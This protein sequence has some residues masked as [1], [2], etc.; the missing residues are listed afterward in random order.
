[1][2]ATKQDL[3]IWFGQGTRKG[4]THMI[5]VQDRFDHGNYP[6]YVMPGED[7]NEREKEL[8]FRDLAGI[9]EIYDLTGDMAEQMSVRRVFRRDMAN[10][11]G[12][13][14]PVDV[15]VKSGAGAP[16][17]PEDWTPSE[18]E[19]AAALIRSSRLAAAIHAMEEA[20]HPTWRDVLRLHNLGTYTTLVSAA[21]QLGY[22]FY[23]W[24]G[25]VY[26]TSEQFMLEKSLRKCTEEAV[27]GG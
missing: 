3:R 7:V 18:M 8:L 9:D 4:A 26:W 16:S 20:P 17:I 25:W 14:T 6:V 24:N 10:P 5:V 19:E 1:M 23:A 12:A 22:P 2:T 21:V 11:P 15:P 13:S 27:S